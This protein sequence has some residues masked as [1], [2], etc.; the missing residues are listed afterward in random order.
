MGQAKRRS[1]KKSE[2][3]LP[4]LSLNKAN[5]D[6]YKEK[7]QARLALLKERWQALP[8][9]HRRAL[10]CAERNPWSS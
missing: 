10:S 5:L 6:V 2:F 7:L 8:K 4:D 3:K 9:L 1:K